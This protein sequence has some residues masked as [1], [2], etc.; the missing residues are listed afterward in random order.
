M[1]NC[2]A[3]PV[4]ATHQHKL[5]L[6][7]CNQC[8]KISTPICLSCRDAGAVL[9]EMVYGEA[10][11]RETLRSA[12]PVPFVYREALQDLDVGGYKVPKVHTSNVPHVASAS[13]T[14]VVLGIIH[15]GSNG[16][17][18]HLMPLFWR[19]CSNGIRWREL[20][21]CLSRSSAAFAQ[22]AGVYQS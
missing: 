7:D 17:V 12:P 9:E 10:V 3:G 13:R 1:N 8:T 18:P 19:A 6:A 20:V 5:P 2:G 16:I 15:K 11:L 4:L 14:C 22:L 21:R